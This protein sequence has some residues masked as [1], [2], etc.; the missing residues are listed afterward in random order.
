VLTVAVLGPVEVRRDDAGLLIPGGKTAEVLVRLA[1]DAGELVRTERLIQDLWS[2][3]AL[4]TAR[5]TLQSKVSKLRRVLRDPGLVRGGSSGYILDVG[6]GC[7][8]ALEVLRLAESAN[9]LREAGDADAALQ[10]CAT[11]LA[12]FRGEIL[13]SAGDGEW[14]APYRARLEETRLRLTEDHLAARID[15]G[16]AGELVGEL[17]GLVAVHPLREGLW[18]LLITAL[19]RA[20]R[21]ADAL[22]AYRRVQQRLGEDLGLDPSSELQALERQVLQH[23]RGLDAPVRDVPAALAV[24]A[25][26][27]LSGLP[28]LLVGREADLE[29]VGKLVGERRLVTV[30]GPAGVGKTRLA[31]DVARGVQPVGGAWLVRLES[32]RTGAS[33]WQSVGEAFQVSAATDAMVLDRLRG[34]E[35]LLVLDNCEHL[36]ETLPE[37]VDRMLGAAP[38][39]RVLAT[40]QLPLGVDGEVGYPLEPLSIADSVVLFTRRAA[41]RRK[42]FSL[43]AGT[44]DIVEA[45]CRSLDGLPLAIELAAARVNALSVQ[46]IARRLGDRFTL[47]SDP[48]SRRPPRQRALRAAIAW[49]Y[50][51]LFPDDQRGLWALACFPGGAP[52]G[53]AEQVLAALD[54]PAVSAMDVVGRLAD[55]SLVAVDVGAGAA[56]RYRLLDSVREFSIDKLRMAGAADIALG[57]LASWFAEAASR[58]ARGVRGPDQAEHLSLVRT[59]RANIDAALAW[60]QSHDPLLGLRIVNGFGWAWAVLVAGPEAAQRVRAAVTAAGTVATTP[61]RAT[62]LLLAGW[63]EASGGNLDSATD[64][65]EQAMQIADDEQRGVGR[66]YLSFIRSQQGRPQDA[67]ELLAA[68]RADFHR[69]GRQWEEGASWLLSAWA[70]I[71]LGETARGKAACDQAL[72]LLDPLGDQWALNHAEGMLG[73]L[74]KAEHRFA[75]AAAHLQ[76]AADATHKLGFAAAEAHHL[77]NLGRA[78][79]ECGDPQAAIATLKRAVDTANAT[80]DLRT[81]A[82]ASARLGR[83]LRSLG[84]RRPARVAAQSAQR[85]YSAAAGGDGAV[86]AQYVIAALDADDGA[87]HAG[88]HLSAVLA[89]ARQAHDVEIEVL[90]LDTM[91]R[92][93]AEHGRMTD[94]RTALDTADHLVPSARHLLTDNDR[95]D[96]DRTR[97]LLQHHGQDP[98]AARPSPSSPAKS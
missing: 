51:L 41:Q 96:R 72:R 35:L 33:V 87:P 9:S 95:I 62:G 38:G 20:G 31:I 15:L 83:V 79:E 43:D 47:L 69:L 70:E 89:A 12:M 3:Q 57:A 84:E 36:V 67:L 22:A 45:V 27:N 55:R 19:Y 8:D 46:E 1:L 91:A 61:D 49:S 42:S 16:A 50:D 58:A 98:P 34:S 26:G 59:E 94:A 64:D 54:V 7:V 74:A 66:L 10:A 82:L 25:R 53:A 14:V 68:C 63:L 17:E 88:Q 29:A 85:W 86:L 5:N 6:R 52:L 4:G 71:A 93:H 92:I 30:V 44:G 78:Q 37:M 90:A 81:G 32:A 60:A 75:D 11:A 40:S 28:G 80:G 18:R 56:V 48:S 73:G 13:P 2:E 77:T 65:L 24:P 97:T 21:Q 39:L 76:R 23:D